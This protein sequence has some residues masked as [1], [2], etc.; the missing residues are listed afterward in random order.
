MKRF[1][2]MPFGYRFRGTN[3]VEFRLWAPAAETITL[4]HRQDSNQDW[5]SVGMNHSSG[6]WFEQ[7]VSL[8]PAGSHYRFR[9][10]DGLCVPD[11]ASRYQPEGVHEYSL[12]IDPQGFVWEDQEWKGRPWEETL[13]YE[14][15]LGSFSPEGN[16]LGLQKRLD[17]LVDLGITAVELMPLSEAP[18]QRNWGYDGVYPYAPNHTY[19]HPDELK[20]LINQAHRR[21]LM[22]FLDVVYNH[23]GPEGNYLH[24][25][26]P[27]FFTDRYQTPW[28]KAINFDDDYST[29]VRGF[30]IDN[31]LYW[32]NEFHIDGLR[33]DAVHAIYDRSR[34]DFLEEL[35]EIVRRE[36]D[37][38]RQV[39]LILENDA[40]DSRYLGRKTSPSPRYDAQWNDD[41]HHAAHVL[42]TD[43]STGYYADY[44]DQPLQHLARCLSE[45]FAYQN[46]YS[47]FRGEV[48]GEP[49]T[50]LPTSAFVNFLQNHDQVGN[51]PFGDR[52]STMTNDSA[53]RALVATLLL[54]PSPPLLFMGEEWGTQTP[55][56]YFCDF[57]EDLATAVREGRRREFSQYPEFSSD[58]AR[59]RIPD[60]NEMSSFQ[61]SCLDWEELKLS[62]H[63]DWLNFYRQLIAIRH[64]KVVPLIPLLDGKANHCLVSGTT[65]QISWKARDASRL[66]LIANLNS[67]PA[68]I[69]IAML[70]PERLYAS[71]SLGLE[72]AKIAALP[73]WF[74]SWHFRPAEAAQ[75]GEQVQSQGEHPNE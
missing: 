54:A 53:L 66:T 32:L 15:H 20:A 28:G 70:E 13:I 73:P 43:E 26:A 69:K 11:P 18:G 12:V 60:P 9:L 21:G 3:E 16:Y 45:G 67:E 46:D 51:R 29:T 5:S 22:V 17:H 23:F 48:R 6:G 74:V 68:D 52:L 7:Q 39:H 36:T 19:G 1:H 8:C 27:N 42:L 14:L 10:P 4:E 49:S 31:A 62:Q 64:K 24:T 71:H 56:R 44:A 75:Q 33:L 41:A 25:Y 37:S 61:E 40:N 57:E 59:K 63:Q 65:L 38:D 55:F 72:E 47:N 35:A 58:E 50:Q 2:A 34:P 30:F